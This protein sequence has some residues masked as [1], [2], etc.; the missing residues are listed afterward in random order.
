M[1]DKSHPANYGMLHTFYFYY[2]K[3]NNLEKLKIISKVCQSSDN[4]QLRGS[5]LEIIYEQII[6]TSMYTLKTTFKTWQNEIFVGIN[7]N[8][9]W[10]IHISVLIL[11]YLKEN[12]VNTSKIKVYEKSLFHDFE[13]YLDLDKEFDEKSFIINL[14]KKKKCMM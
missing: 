14:S 4:A 13:N 11:R 8:D 3:T 7:D 12:G 1:E 5:V 10:S 6:N 2:K 9:I